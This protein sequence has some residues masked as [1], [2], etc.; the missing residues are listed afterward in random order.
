MSIFSS[1]NVAVG[2][3]IATV[4]TIADLRS[5]QPR[6]LKDGD[7]ILVGGKTTFAD[8]DGGAYVWSENSTATDDGQITI[9][10]D[11]VMGKGRWI[12][13]L[14]RGNTGPQGPQGIQ[15]IPGNTALAEELTLTR[16]PYKNLEYK[17]GIGIYGTTYQA[18]ARPVNTPRKITIATFGN[19]H[20]NGQ[21]TSG[22]AV[23]P[24]EQLKNVFAN[25]F[26]LVQF[27]H[28]NYSVS[29]SWQ[30]QLGDQIDAMNRANAAA[31]DGRSRIPDIV[32]ILDPTND[33]LTT[34]Y[35]SLEGPQV[36][37][38]R[39]YNN[40]Q[41]F[42]SIGATVLNVTAPQPHPTRSL[43]NGRFDMSE[44]F[45]ATWPSVSF[46]AGD[47]FQ[48]FTYSKAN[49]TITTST[50]GQFTI[51][52]NGWF[53]AGQWIKDDQGTFHYI[54]N[55][56]PTGTVL[57]VATGP[58]GG[59][60]IT[61]DRYTTNGLIQARID[62]ETQLY[63]PKSQSIVKRDINNN[64]VMISVSARHV[65]LNRI[66]REVTAQTGAIL[67][68]WARA[69]E[70]LLT[71]DSVYDT[72]YTNNDDFHMGDPGHMLLTPLFQTVAQKL[73]YGA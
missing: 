57:T 62:A 54:K 10:P 1:I 42:Q 66:C 3:Y 72:L 44:A 38:D 34:I 65:Q 61:A 30:T 59:P 35:H 37:H 55:I 12:I 23:L 69:Q 58:T 14:G 46:V 21:N 28:D 19:S 8:R 40:I 24:G 39:L 32:L 2:K 25:R 18:N 47:G 16:D 11:W 26:P 53:Q 56:D 29:G 6:S 4:P 5:Y 41:Y 63:P 68:D 13:V 50:V 27:F 31:N 7:T 60:S 71:S 49:Q 36:Y 67:I 17:L 20:G 43:A 48:A 22:G 52:A 45:F 64:G 51:Y 33:G 9:L 15:G 73:A 70:K